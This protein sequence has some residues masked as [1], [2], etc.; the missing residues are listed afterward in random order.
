VL[1]LFF[2]RQAGVDLGSVRLLPLEV[3]LGKGGETW[4]AEWEVLDAVRSGRA[5]AGVVGE[6]AWRAAGEQGR[7]E[8]LSVVWSSPACDGA[9]FCSLVSVPT[10]LRSAFER[11]MREMSPANPAQ[12]RVLEQVGVS[13]WVPARASGYA[14]LRQAV[15]EL[16]AG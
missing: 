14:A 9:V 13:G 8:G 11:V 16:A 3:D 12:R 10:V 7:C 15:D 4:R 6:R 5:A 1:P 2:L